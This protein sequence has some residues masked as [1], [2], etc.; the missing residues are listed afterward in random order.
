MRKTTS[1]SNAA[2]KVSSG[3]S[4]LHARYAFFLLFFALIALLLSIYTGPATA[5]TQDVAPAVLRSSA[6]ALTLLL[7]H[8]FGDAFAPSLVGMLATALDVTRQHFR[9]GLAGQD[10]RVALLWTC[11]PA[12]LLAGLIGMVGAR[13]MDQDVVAAEQANQNYARKV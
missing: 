10:L 13:W 11:T 9:A 2:T 7:A 5:A 12:L 3:S 1:F 6:V 8:L 4:S